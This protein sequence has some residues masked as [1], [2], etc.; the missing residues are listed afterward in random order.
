MHQESKTE[1]HI[2]LNV[3]GLSPRDITYW[4]DRVAEI[5]AVLASQH[6][7]C[8]EVWVGSYIGPSSDPSCQFYLFGREVDFETKEDMDRHREIESR[9][10]QTLQQYLL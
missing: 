6:N 1:Y 2:A 7:I 4:H 5:R 8:A 10:E 9:I 3:R